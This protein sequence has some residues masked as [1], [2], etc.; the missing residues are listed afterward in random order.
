MLHKSSAIDFYKTCG[1]QIKKKLKYYKP[2]TSDIKNV[3][4]CT[5]DQANHAFGN[6]VARIFGGQRV[7]AATG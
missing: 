4:S 1:F 3:R 6:V 7:G 5:V 2:T